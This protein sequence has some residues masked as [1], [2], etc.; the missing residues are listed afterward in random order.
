MKDFI[1]ESRTHFDAVTDPLFASLK[2]GEELT[3]NLVAEESLFVRF[4]ANR[5]RQ[6]TNVEQRAI[7]LKLQADGRTVEKSRTLTG[8]ADADRAAL[9]SLLD[10]CRAEAKQ[11]PPDPNQVPMQ[12]NGESSEEFRG[13]LLAPE[14]AVR[15]VAGS[16]EGL[17]LAGLYSGGPAIRANRN[18]KGQ[19]HWFATENFF[20]DYSLYNGPK[21]AKGTYAGARWSQK[22]W[23]KNLHHTRDQLALLSKPKATVKPGQYR[24]YLAPTAFANLCGMMGWGALSGAAWKQGYSAFKKFADGEVTLS[25]LFTLR[26]NFGLGL[27]PRFNELGE[28]APAQ[29]PLIENGKL[30]SLLVSSRTAKEFGL[31]GNFASGQEAPR[32]LEVLPGTLAERDVLKEL[33]TGLYLSNLHYLN[34][35]DPVSARITGMTRYACFWVEGGEIAGPI[36]DLRWDES[37][38]EALGPKLLAL[39]SHSET[40]PA[41]ETYFHR[42]LGGSRTPGAL[43]DRFTYTL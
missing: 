16:A 14:D 24:T 20:L 27:T 7:S 33:G 19:R 26:E 5:V 8:R 42:A 11:L 38:Y 35:S 2:A 1:K 41:T 4:N 6:N 3:A 30:A 22:D 32:A 39:T 36:Q 40:D 37:L 25:K 17:D 18:S 15:A 34:W 29:L 13:A 28:V 23:E 43:I 21:A 31:K 10:A 9:A 12:N